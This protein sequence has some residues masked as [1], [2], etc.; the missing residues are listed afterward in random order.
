MFYNCKNL[1][2]I[3]DMSN[4]KLNQVI[5]MSNLFAGCSSLETINGLQKWNISNV[6]NLSDIQLIYYM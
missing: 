1:S 2:F 5:D 4:L 3:T 6:I